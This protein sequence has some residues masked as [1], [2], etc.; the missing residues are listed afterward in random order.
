MGSDKALLRLPGGG[1]TLIER[2]VMAARAAGATD[3]VIVARAGQP[4]PAMDGGRI[5][6][7]ETPGAGP[8]AGL[9]TGLAAARHDAALALACDLPY[10]SVP[11]LRWMATEPRDGWDALV[12]LLPDGDHAEGWE[13]LHALYTRAC[14][15]PIRTALTRGERRMTATF[16]HLRVR[17]LTAGEMRP[18]D[19]ALLSS[20]SVNTPLAWAEA[21]R[22]LLAHDTAILPPTGER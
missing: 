6:A 1:P 12:P 7:D 20:R 8:L 10:L 21:A 3:V 5:M 17:P 18:Y 15:A 16:P 4:L 9:A 14:L 22:W 2:T 19:P 13:P 11:L